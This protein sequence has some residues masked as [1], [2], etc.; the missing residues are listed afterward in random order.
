MARAREEAGDSRLVSGREP[1]SRIIRVSVKTPQ[2]CQEFLLAEN[3]NVHRFKKQISKYLQCDTDRLVLIFSGKILR[4]QD[5]LSKR[6]I[7]DGSTV[8]VVV[9]TRLKGSACMGALAGPTGHCTHRSEP[10]ASDSAGVLA[11][12]GRLARTS[13]DLADFFSQLVQLLTM[14]PESVVQFLEDPLIQGLANEKQANG[15]H[16][17][18]SSKTVQRRDPALKFPETFPK[19]AQQQEV[20]QE[21]RQRLEAPK[22]VPGGDNAMRPGCSDIQQIM[23]STLAFLVSSKGHISGLE[24]CRGEAANAHSNSDPSITIPATSVPARPFAQEVSTGGITQIKGIV[25]S[26][27]SLGCRPGTLDLQPGSD[28]PFQ[29]YQ[30]PVEKAPSV[31]Q[32]RP[33]PYVLCRALNVLQQNPALLHQLA[34]GSPLLH[35]MPLLPILTNPRALQALLQI[36][37]GLQILSREV[38]ELGPFLWDS[39]KPRGARGA[40]ETRGRRQAHRED[41]SQHYLAYLQLFHSLANACSQSTQTGLSL[42]LLIEGRYQQELEQLKALGF[43]NH[44]ANLQALIATD[45]DI[46]AAIER[47]LGAPQA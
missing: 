33:S 15:L 11:R 1:S 38:P 24:M 9:R 22:A 18:E 46:H 13:P 25:S 16:V 35:H 39:A 47:I 41:T 20:L 10:S 36:E 7:L 23:L 4:D 32:L 2:D 45:G 19:P 26:Q 14:A 8:H 6:G 27:A 42:P 34:T 12:L 37:Q 21:H 44:D 43:A 31:G 28:L 29:E 40:P 3:S 17:P 5:I 30:P